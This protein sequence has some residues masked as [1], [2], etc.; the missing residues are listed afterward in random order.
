MKNKSNENHFS[1]VFANKSWTNEENDWNY[2]RYYFCKH[3]KKVVEAGRYVGKRGW[4]YEINLYSDD[5]ES[6]LNKELENNAKLLYEK[7][8]NDVIL[9]ADERMCWGQFIITQAIRTPSFFKYRDKI[10]E[11]NDGDYSY[12]ETIIGCP[13]CEDNKNIACRNWI[14]LNSHVDDFFIRTDNPVYMT[15]FIENPLTTI[16]YPLTPRKC[17]VACSMPKYIPVLKGY[18][19]PMPWQD[20]LQLEKGDAY[21]INFELI[22]SASQSLILDKNNNNVA[23]NSMILEVLGNYPQLPFLMFRADNDYESLQKQ[24][25]LTN[26]VSYVDGV[27]YPYIEYKFKPFYGVEFSNGINPFSLFGVTDN[28]LPNI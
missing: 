7:L 18:E 14:I 11:Q 15:G 19:P 16:F 1:P 26:L 17:F 23:I 20:T 22:Q 28:Q 8:I 21:T 4:G 24:E 5:L 9:T 10:E 3:R 6:R 25:L 13:E 27:K 12:K 2:K